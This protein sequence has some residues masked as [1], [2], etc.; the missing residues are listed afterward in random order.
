MHSPLRIFCVVITCICA[1][2]CAYT[3]VVPIAPDDHQTRGFRHYDVKPLLVLTKDG[4]QVALVPNFNKAYAVQFGAFLSKNDV[5][6][7]WA[8]NGTLSKFGS[9]LDSTAVIDL[10]KVAA[11]PLIGNARARDAAAGGGAGKPVVYEFVFDKQGNLQGLRRL[12][13]VEAN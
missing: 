12:N 9:K 2:A 13:V 7:E 3:D 4:Y 8:P 5:T 10:L 6:F 11:Q 1:Q